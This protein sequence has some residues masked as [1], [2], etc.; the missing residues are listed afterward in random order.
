MSSKNGLWLGLM[1]SAVAAFSPNC[2][3]GGNFDLSKWFLQLPVGSPGSPTQ[4]YSSQL[5]GCGGLQN[6]WFYTAGGDGYGDGG[7]R[8]LPPAAA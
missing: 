8:L 5:K 1:A 2:A 6:Q 3:P 4:I 7:P